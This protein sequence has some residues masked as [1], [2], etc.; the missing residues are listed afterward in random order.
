[1]IYNVQLIIRMY[2][3]IHYFHGFYVA[4]SFLK[5]VIQ[6]FYNGSSYIIHYFFINKQEQI[7]EKVYI[8]MDIDDDFIR[9]D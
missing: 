2:M 7:E 8:I 1:M 9:V 3:Y 4:I 6:N 5:Y